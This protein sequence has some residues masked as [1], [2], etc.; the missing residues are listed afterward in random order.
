M[1]IFYL[2]RFSSQLLACTPCALRLN[3]IMSAT[4]EIY[5]LSCFGVY[6]KKK[7]KKSM[8]NLVLATG[9]SPFKHHLTWSAFNCDNKLGIVKLL[10][11]N[12]IKNKSK[13]KICG[14]LF[15]LLLRSS[16]S[17]CFS[18]KQIALV[19]PV[20]QEKAFCHSFYRYHSPAICTVVKE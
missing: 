2:P 18:G 5:F 3:V 9:N 6:W 10:R 20:K 14:W 4:W 8:N 13:T 1:P 11:T 15:V 19:K 7:H 17:V 16:F 12:Y